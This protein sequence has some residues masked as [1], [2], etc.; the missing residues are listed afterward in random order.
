MTREL[1]QRQQRAIQALITT[2]T[3]S[4]AAKKA[5]VSERSVYL[6]INQDHFQTSLRDAREKALGHTSTRVQQITARAVKTLEDIMDDDKNS[7]SS[8]VSAVRLSLDMMYRAR[9][10][11]DI[12]ERLHTLEGNQAG[13]Q[14]S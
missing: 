14:T 3:I 2:N 7:A 13:D 6:W 4:Q 12:V 9:A 1:T 11:D 8:R 10:I 5:K